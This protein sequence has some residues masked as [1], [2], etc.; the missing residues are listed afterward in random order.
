MVLLHELQTDVSVTV[1]L[2]WCTEFQYSEL[3]NY[4]NDLPLLKLIFETISIVRY[5]SQEGIYFQK[6][7]HVI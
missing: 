2:K 6:E 5:I 3:V 1:C 4:S 7:D